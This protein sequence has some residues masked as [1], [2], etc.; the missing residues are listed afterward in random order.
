MP[1]TSSSCAG[2]GGPLA[3]LGGQCPGV[4]ARNK[5]GCGSASHG[6]RDIFSGERLQGHRTGRV[7]SLWGFSVRPRRGLC[8][9]PAGRGRGE[10]R[11]ARA[12]PGIAVPY[13][14]PD[15]G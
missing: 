12:W 5:A 9:N 6:A 10:G 1:E 15:I 2:P 8:S 13:T 11:A 14:R 4:E 3:P 7:W